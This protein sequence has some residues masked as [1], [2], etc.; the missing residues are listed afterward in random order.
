MSDPLSIAASV[1]GL[2]SLGLQA[3]EYLVKCYQDCRHRHAD[4]A[5]TTAKLEELIQSLETLNE[6]IKSRKWRAGDEHI[7]T[8]IE[9]S[10]SSSGHHP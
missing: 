9:S 1:A 8:T 10:I 6:V 7:L 3:T 2:V 4:L 5:K